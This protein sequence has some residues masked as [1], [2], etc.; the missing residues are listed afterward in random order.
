VSLVVI[1]LACGSVDGPTVA[2]VASP[3]APVDGPSVYLPEPDTVERVAARHLLV[4]Y[5]GALAAPTGV[6]RTKDEARAE[7]AALRQQLLAGADFHQLAREHSS[8]GTRGR[9]G[10]LGSFERGTMAPAF[11]DALWRLPIGGLSEPVETPY[12]FHLILREP[13]EEVKLRH[14]L[15]QHRDV[16]R[17]TGTVVADDRSVE[18]A[19]ALVEHARSE[20]LAGR[21]FREV[22]IE[23][24][25][26]E[27]GRRGGEVGWFFL[28]ELGADFDEAVADLEPGEVSEVI[29]TPLGFHLVERVE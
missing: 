20:V 17:S 23:V 27:L 18:E 15:V 25:G 10:W 5:E 6:T 29:E 19:R 3:D 4:P 12:G 11:E 1:W 24:G 8:D 22:A 28:A 9:G 26:T 7:I 13:L 16:P 2:P 21:A 14:I